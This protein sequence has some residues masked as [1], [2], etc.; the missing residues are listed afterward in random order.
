MLSYLHMGYF[1][2][3]LHY[4]GVHEIVETRYYLR[5]FSTGKPYT[6]GSFTTAVVLEVV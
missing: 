4:L 6:L 5:K 2:P 1:A 3:R